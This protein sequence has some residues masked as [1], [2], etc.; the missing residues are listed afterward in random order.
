[1][2]CS[3]GVLTREARMAAMTG[4]LVSGLRL[5]GVRTGLRQLRLVEVVGVNFLLGLGQYGEC[6]NDSN[7]EHES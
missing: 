1:M 7:C 6:G 3:A 4:A 2:V 5:C